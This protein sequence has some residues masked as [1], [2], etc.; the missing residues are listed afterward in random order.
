MNRLFI[1]VGVCIILASCKQN[2]PVEN[3]V[4]VQYKGD[5]VYV[6]VNSIVNS[7]IKLHTV[8]E[9]N[10]N[11]EFNT[12]GTVKAIAGQMAEIASPLDGR[13]GRS[14]IQL[15]QR[16][17]AGTPVFELH[18]AD[19]FEATKGYFQT[20]Q[21][22]KMKESNLQRQQDLVKNG[23]GVA[24]ELEEAETDYEVALKDYE[25]AEATLKMFNINPNDI[26]MGQA[27]KVTSPIV[28]EVVQ[29][30]IVIGQ[31]VK[32]DA[33]PLVIVAELDKVWVVAQVKEK[34]IHSIHTDNK[35]EI[36]TDSDPE[37][38]ITGHVS[39]ISELLN[40]ETRS[41]QVLI[42][43][44]NK[45]RRLKP[46][47]FTSVHFINQPQRSILVPS[48]SLLQKEDE[49]YVFVKSR[50]GEYVRRKVKT[51][52]TNPSESLITEGLKAGDVIVSGGGI[53]LMEN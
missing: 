5:T 37:Y 18:S 48:T 42:T 40:E 50:E 28:G 30:N 33:A 23:V 12:T 27:L 26:A 43:C 39:H 14:F 22:K 53:Y 38:A 3:E 15:G 6:A 7:K 31:Y 17:S 49:T 21:T 45:D 9:Q 52:T 32:S 35:V 34:Y 10:Y 25:N 4:G 46:G 41:V 44:D 20:L 29:V 24:K 19:F 2:K 11:T 47:M 1:L 36:R 13:V 16:V 8:I 51:A